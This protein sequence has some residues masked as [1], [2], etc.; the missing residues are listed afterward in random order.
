[1]LR[2]FMPFPSLGH[3]F[4]TLTRNT[5][6]KA[7]S[8]S[9]ETST[10]CAKKSSKEQIDLAQVQGGVYQGNKLLELLG[11]LFESQ[12]IQLKSSAL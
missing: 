1:M 3:T 11:L 9:Q 10:K 5:C 12:I 7:E 8:P 6:L 4:E 2:Y